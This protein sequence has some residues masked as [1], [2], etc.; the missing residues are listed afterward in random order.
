MGERHLHYPG[1]LPNEGAYEAGT[2]SGE[3]GDLR[4]GGH[5]QGQARE[6]DCEGVPSR[7]SEGERL[8]SWRSR[9]PLP[10]CFSWANRGSVSASACMSRGSA[11]ACVL[12]LAGACT[13]LA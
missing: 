7:C 3:E 12:N 10:T 9:G 2:E 6:E 13:V 5:G 11:S 8:K 1:S 4:Q